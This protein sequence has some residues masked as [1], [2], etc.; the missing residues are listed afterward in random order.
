MFETVSKFVGDASLKQLVAARAVI[1]AEIEI[2][3]NAARKVREAKKAQDATVTKL[4][5]AKNG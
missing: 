3:R 4:T 2:R 1:D 5:G